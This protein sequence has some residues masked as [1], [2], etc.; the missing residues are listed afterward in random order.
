[1]LAFWRSAFS[2]GLIDLRVETQSFEAEHEIAYGVGNYR[3]TVE[4]HPGM[5]QTVKGKYLVLYH[6]QPDGSW[7]IAAA[8][9]NPGV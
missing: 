1:V 5:L 8:S 4:T 7:R 3:T 6:R 9:F 2:R